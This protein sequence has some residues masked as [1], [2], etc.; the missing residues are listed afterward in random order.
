VLLNP[1]QKR[2]RIS[3]KAASVGASALTH[4]ILA[5]SAAADLDRLPLGERGGQ[6]ELWM[7]FLDPIVDRGGCKVIQQGQVF[8]AE[9]EGRGRA[10]AVGVPVSA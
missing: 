9:G 1:E 5:P 10:A 2:S 8:Q 3:R 7:R 6:R 4:A